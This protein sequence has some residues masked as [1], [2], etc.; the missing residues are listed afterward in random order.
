MLHAGGCHSR[1]AVRMRATLT[2]IPPIHTHPS[3]SHKSLPFPPILPIPTHPSHSQVLALFDS[4]DA[5]GSGTIG[6]EDAAGYRP[7]T[8][9]LRAASTPSV[10]SG[11]GPGMADAARP[12]ATGGGTLASRIWG[13]GGRAQVGSSEPLS[14]PLVTKQTAAAGPVD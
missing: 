14:E 8:A 13:G 2:A 5:D 1:L 9:V 10:V 3:H 12:T 7:M 4:L 6:P 11:R